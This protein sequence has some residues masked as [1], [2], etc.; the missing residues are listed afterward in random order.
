MELLD[1]FKEASKQKNNG[2]MLSWNLS[3]VSLLKQAMLAKILK[4][5][6]SKHAK[7]SAT[8]GFLTS[9]GGNCLNRSHL[10]F[11]HHCI[12]ILGH[13][14]S[15]LIPSVSF[16]PHFLHSHPQIHL[17]SFWHTLSHS[18]TLSLTLF[19][20]HLLSFFLTYSLSFSLTLF[21][22]HLLSISLTYYCLSF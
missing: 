14:S 21:L 17:R 15:S 6:S 19:L 3:K 18:L 22:S 1:N 5:K 9:L 10:I 13:A 16:R 11:F 7:L 4:F 2:R 20:S 12:L 8:I